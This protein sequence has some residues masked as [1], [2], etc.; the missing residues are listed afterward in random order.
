MSKQWEAFQSAMKDHGVIFQTINTLDVLSTASGGFRRQT[1]V[2]GDLDLLLT[3]DG[4]RLLDWN[5]A[6]FFVYGLG[7][8]GD[9]PT[10]NVGDIQG[11]SSIAAPNI[12]KLF[13]VWYQQNFF[14]LKTPP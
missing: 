9:D 1:A 14:P 8:Y 6:T 7:L 13:E 11:V 3:L 12:W 10:Q 4:E 2:A 5:D